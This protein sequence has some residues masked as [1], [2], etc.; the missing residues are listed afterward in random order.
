MRNTTEI[1]PVV[2]GGGSKFE[3][4]S[5]KAMCDTYFGT[6]KDGKC[7]C[8][9]KVL[10]VGEQCESGNIVRFKSNPSAALLKQDVMD[11]KIEKVDMNKPI[12]NLFG[13][14]SALGTR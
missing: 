11:F 14:T 1:Q 10:K 2:A 9:G 8:D 7:F 5:S 6:F 13:G 4:S 3:P 12:G